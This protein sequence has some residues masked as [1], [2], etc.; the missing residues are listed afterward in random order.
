MDPTVLAEH[1][2]LHE[3]RYYSKVRPQEGL[4]WIKTRTGES[5]ANLLAFCALHDKL[6]AW[7]KHS[8]LWTDGLGR[9]ADV[10][11]LWIKIAEVRPTIDCL[12]S[13]YLN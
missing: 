11:E 9:R 3:Y 8:I 7:V 1:L 5:V 2:C 12:C 10:I 6:A 13:E 4:N